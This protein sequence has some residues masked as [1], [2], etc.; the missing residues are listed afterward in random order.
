M[1]AAT[2]S[3]MGQGGLVSKSR[4]AG[5]AAGAAKAGLTTV[6]KLRVGNLDLNVTQD[7]IQELFAEIGTCKSVELMTRADGGSKGFA[8]VVYV[9]KADAQKAMD[10]Y[11]GVPL[12]GRPLKITLEG[13]TMPSAG[14]AAAASS[15]AVALSGANRRAFVATPQSVQSVRAAPFS[16]GRGSA[17]GRGSVGG[18]GGRGAGRSG[19]GGNPPKAEDLDA[20]LEAYRAGAA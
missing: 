1:A 8:F 7:D 6:T 3:R 14:A 2:L 4:A 10:T 19:R 11:N 17:A 16:R 15:I 13:P 20:D 5:V 12:D 9:R 18:R